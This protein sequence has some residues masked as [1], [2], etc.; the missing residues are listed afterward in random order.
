M[1]ASVREAGRLW[2]KCQATRCG[3]TS[4]RRAEGPAADVTSAPTPRGE[5]ASGDGPVFFASAAA[6]SVASRPTT[7]EGAISSM[8][9]FPRSPPKSKAAALRSLSWR[10]PG[11]AHGDRRRLL[12]P[13]APPRGLDAQSR[14]DDTPRPTIGRGRG[15]LRSRTNGCRRSPSSPWRR[16]NSDYV[17]GHG[18]RSAALAR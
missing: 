16:R 7:R 8:S 11:S 13:R 1:C 6:P 18:E 17:E 2:N 12:E 3:D 15:R 9:F 14:R 10:T 4:T 5:R